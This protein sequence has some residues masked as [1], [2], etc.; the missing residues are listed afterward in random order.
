LGALA[1]K[2][3]AVREEVHIDRMAQ[4]IGSADWSDRDLRITAIDAETGEP[5]AWSRTDGVPLAVAVASSSAIPGIYSPITIKGR[6]YM[7]GGMRTGDNVHL[8]ESADVLVVLEP[9]GGMVGGSGRLTT[10]IKAVV[11]IAPDE[12]ARRVFIPSGLAALWRGLMLRARPRSV[13]PGMWTSAYDA[14]ARQA[15]QTV[16]A[17]SDIWTVNR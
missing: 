4:L 3:S 2:S 1:L 8:A 13:L 10:A 11:R 7:D 15:D 12:E 9:L 5:R 17:I 6:R 16:R 14:G